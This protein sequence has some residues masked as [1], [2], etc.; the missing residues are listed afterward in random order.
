MRDHLESEGDQAGDDNIGRIQRYANANANGWRQ[1]SRSKVS[2]QPI[3]ATGFAVHNAP[4]L[5]ADLL[6]L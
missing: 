6:T 4:A 1:T 2:V 5:V 3:K